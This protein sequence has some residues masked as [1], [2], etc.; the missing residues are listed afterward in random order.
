LIGALALILFLGPLQVA[1]A[2]NFRR[3]V[4]TGILNQKYVPA[5]LLSMTYM[6]G[7]ND[8]YQSSAAMPAS[9]GFQR[10]IPCAVFLMKNIQ[11]QKPYCQA[12]IGFL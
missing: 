8:Q 11:K 1:F 4:C 10:D 9:K 12:A 7:R 5:V 3:I 6:H 2:D